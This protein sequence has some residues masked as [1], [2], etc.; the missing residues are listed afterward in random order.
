MPNIR[1]FVEQQT[2]RLAHVLNCLFYKFGILQVLFLETKTCQKIRENLLLLLLLP[3]LLLY[4]RQGSWRVT[5]NYLRRA[6][7]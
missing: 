3:L 5:K 1:F 7:L 6:C 4:V 2:S